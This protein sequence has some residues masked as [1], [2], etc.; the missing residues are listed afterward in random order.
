MVFQRV[1]GGPPLE[2]LNS[3]IVTGIGG[4]GIRQAARLG[5][6]SRANLL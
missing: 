3:T 4:H 1:A 6:G 5:S 2:H